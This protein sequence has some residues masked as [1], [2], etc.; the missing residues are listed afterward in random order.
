MVCNTTLVLLTIEGEKK[1][2]NCETKAINQADLKLI[3]CST[4][5]CKHLGLTIDVT[6]RCGNASQA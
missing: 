4:I 5:Y 6:G 3:K 1:M 2:L